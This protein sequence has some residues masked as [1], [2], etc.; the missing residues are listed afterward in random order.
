MMDDADG[1]VK[2]ISGFDLVPDRMPGSQ[3]RGVLAGPESQVALV[4]RNLHQHREVDEI[5]QGRGDAELDP[6]SRTTGAGEAA[7]APPPGRGGN[8]RRP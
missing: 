1:F 5:R 4:G 2:N 8:R 7:A 6:T 3:E